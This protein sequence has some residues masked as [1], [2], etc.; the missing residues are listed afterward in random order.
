M[1][2]IDWIPSIIT[3]VIVAAAFGGLLVHLSK[4]EK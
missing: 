1:S 4:R 2:F 3:A